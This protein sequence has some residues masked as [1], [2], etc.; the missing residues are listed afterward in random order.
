M[1]A[2]EL[3]YLYY[4][5]EITFDNQGF[6]E[7]SRDI[8]DMVNLTSLSLVNNRLRELPKEI[9]N[10]SLNLKK[11]FLG[12][13][14]FTTFP[15]VVFSLTQLVVLDIN[16]NYSMSDFPIEITNMITLE[17]LSIS[18]NHVGHLP[19]EIGNLTRL[20]VLNLSHNIIAHLPTTIENLVNLRELLVDFNQLQ[21]LTPSNGY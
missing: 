16:T 3:Q 15:S 19:N 1:N 6:T 21:S 5:S 9:E 18:W 17:E 13:N 14:F 11:L 7:I 4:C 20:R 8:G 10:L 2:Q 12:E